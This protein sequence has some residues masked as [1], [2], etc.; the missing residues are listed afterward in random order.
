MFKIKSCKQ[1]SLLN[2]YTL[3]TIKS[4]NYKLY[5]DTKEAITKKI[6]A[7]SNQFCK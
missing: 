3:K 6:I 2:F 4:M 5:C 7:Y 1:I